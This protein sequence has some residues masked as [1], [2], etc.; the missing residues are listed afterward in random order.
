MRIAAVVLSVLTAVLAIFT[1]ICGAWIRSKATATGTSIH[2]MLGAAT[3]VA[4]I[5]TAIVVII[6]V[7]R[8][9]R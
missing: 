8:S 3:T 2:A 7:S 9:R 1:A 5:I 6:Y 4:A